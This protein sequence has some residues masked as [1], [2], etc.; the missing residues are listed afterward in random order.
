MNGLGI[1]ALLVAVGA[2][3]LTIALLAA[4]RRALPAGRALLEMGQAVEAA[5]AAHD[6]LDQ[7]PA[8]VESP[9]EDAEHDSG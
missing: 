7:Q 1:A 6:A 9:D 5:R 4:R 8:S 3:G 2:G